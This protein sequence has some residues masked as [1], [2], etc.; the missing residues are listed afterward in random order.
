MVRDCGNRPLDFQDREGGGAD[1]SS[2][3]E[4]IVLAKKEKR[5]RISPQLPRAY[6]DFGIML[7]YTPLH[8]MLPGKKNFSR[9]VM[10]SANQVDEPIL[11]RKQGGG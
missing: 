8:H 11:Y 1:F 3:P 6:S 9:L 7:P 10:T 5:E 2:L 4:A